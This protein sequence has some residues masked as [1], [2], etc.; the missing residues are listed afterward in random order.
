ML[1]RGDVAHFNIQKPINITLISG[2]KYPQYFEKTRV[3]EL[4]IYPAPEGIK[5]LWWAQEMAQVRM[6]LPCWKRTRLRDLK[7]L[8][9]KVPQARVAWNCHLRVGLVGTGRS[10]RHITKSVWYGH[11]TSK[12]KNTESRI[13]YLHDQLLFD[14]DI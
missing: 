3:E 6:C 8:V 14:E 9:K 2:I 4:I 1:C 10:L 12:Q 11:R 5:T 7:H 13:L